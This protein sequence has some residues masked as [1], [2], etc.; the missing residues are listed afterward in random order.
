MNYKNKVY[1]ISF[2][3][4][5]LVILTN[6]YFSYDQSI[7]YGGADGQSYMNISLSSPYIIKENIAPIHSERFL[8]P[9]II[10]IISKVIDVTPYRI[11]FFVVLLCIVLINIL[12][13][14]TIENFNNCSKEI[15]FFILLINLNPYI[16]RFYLAVPTIVNDLIFILGFCVFIY[17]ISTK[18][19][20][21]IYYILGIFLSFAA[22]QTS[23]AYIISFLITKLK[24][25]NFFYKRY[26]LLAILFL[27][28][29]L[30]FFF[31]YYYSSL[32]NISAL[33][34]DQYDFKMR[35]FGFFTQD[36][37]IIDKIKFLIL[38]LLSYSPLIIFVIFFSNKINLKNIIKDEISF[39]LLIFICLVIFQPILSGVEIT[40]R[41]IIRLTTLAYFAILIILIKNVSFNT[42]NKIKKLLFFL[43]L[44][45]FSMHPTFSKFQLLNFIRF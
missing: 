14:K 12:I 16:T 17:A 33:R 15:I 34:S 9:Y 43:I 41:N 22:R 23:V 26:K 32:T 27:M 35:F 25:K 19:G 28:I 37:N 39:F 44:V 6:N 10:G 29:I 36:V 31:N 42:K 11:Y 7:I 4:I 5:L 13:I 21:V 18:K 1:F 30:I 2:F 38:P 24:F 45:T 20:G 40:G 3:S 8:F